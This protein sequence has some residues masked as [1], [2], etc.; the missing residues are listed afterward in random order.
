[1]HI[2]ASPVITPGAF[3]NCIGITA[4][5]TFQMGKS[6]T[7][8]SSSPVCR[9]LPSRTPILVLLVLGMLLCLSAVA[10]AQEKRRAVHIA[11]LVP[12]DNRPFTKKRMQPAIEIAVDKVKDSLLQEMDVQVHYADSKCDIAH[13]INGA[14]QLHNKGHA[15]VFLGPVCD[16]AAAPVA[17]Q[18]VFWD[19]PVLTYAQAKDFR[20]EKTL[21]KVTRVGNDFFQLG[22]F[23]EAMVSFSYRK[24]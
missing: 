9:L 16:Y 18:S 8:S 6:H 19:T 1:M 4:A 5:E 7:V 10:H 14:I 11:V 13:G 2:K 23:M 3:L 24:N 21:S 20:A 17:R 22:E 12:Y 15:D